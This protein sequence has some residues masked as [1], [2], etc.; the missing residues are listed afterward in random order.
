M[1][2]L[3]AGCGLAAVCSFDADLKHFIVQVPQ[4]GNGALNDFAANVQAL[5]PISFN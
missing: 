3:T 2:P 5:L 1:D 4:R